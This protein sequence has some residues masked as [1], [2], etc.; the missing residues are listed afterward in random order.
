MISVILATFNRASLLPRALDSLLAQTIPDWEVIVVNDGSTDQSLSLLTSYQR[1]DKRV[2]V[3]S[4]GNLGLTKARNAGMRHST[5]DFITF[6]DSDDEYR[7]DHL[8]KRL[9]YMNDHPDIDF[10]HGGCLI[11]GGPTAVPDKFN[12]CRMVELADC[13]IGGTFFMRRRVLDKLSGFRQPDYGNDC[14]FA[15]RA[16]K[17]FRIS[18]VDL[19]TYIYHRETPDSMCRLMENSCQ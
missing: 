11:V 6:L 1:L 5:G 12:P 8:E 14:E 3:V 19:P 16:Q 2:R 4:Q 9:Q 10:V 7:P 15:E 13:F 17:H 18:R